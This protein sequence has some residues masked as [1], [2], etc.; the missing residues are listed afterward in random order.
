[1]LTAKQA[2]DE[3]KYRDIANGILSGVEERIMD[4]IKRGKFSASVSIGINT[5]QGARAIVIDEL[6]ALGYSVEITN[7]D[8]LNRDIPNCT[9]QGYWY[10]T[11]EVS[12][13]E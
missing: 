12:W 7:N 8:E 3:T 9:E 2:R 5:P 13:E 11:V 4:S 1:M 10:D 6:N